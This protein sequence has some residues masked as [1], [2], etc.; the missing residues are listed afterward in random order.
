VR[1]DFIEHFGQYRIAD[2]TVAI[3]REYL[4]ILGHRKTR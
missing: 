4:I 3:P 1:A 2:G